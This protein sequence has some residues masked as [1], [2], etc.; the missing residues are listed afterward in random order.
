VLSSGIFSGA[1]WTYYLYSNN[2][3]VQA[4]AQGQTVTENFTVNGVVGSTNFTFSI[5]GTNDAAVIAGTS[6][7][8]VVEAGGVNNGTAG[9]PTIS[10]TLTSTDVDNA[11][12]SF[13]AVSS[14]T[15]SAGGYG[16]YTMTAAG[17]WTYTLN[18]SN[19]TV[20]AL[21]AGA[22]LTDTFTVTSVDGT[23]KVVTVTINGTNDAAIIA[24]T[25][26]G[27]V[28]EAGGMGNGTA[29]TPT[30]SGTLSSTDVDNAANSFTAVGTATTSTGG[31]GTYTV[32]AAGA[33][34]YTLNNSHITVQ[35]LNVGSTLTDTFT[36]TSIDGTQKVVTVTI[37]GTNDA[38]AI[39]GTSTGTVVEAG[40][41]SNGTAG[42]ARTP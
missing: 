22:T 27:T 18:N 14:A 12:N 5:I 28:V 31:Y 9:T 19:A 33:W 34:T 40:G 41:V 2:S 16:T 24:G 11:A 30:V 1:K 6:T 21:N 42:T 3:N 26:T 8:T 35:A 29:G 37:T 39:T 36:V 23:Q 38:A 25:S 17:V 20:Q 15:A 4:L 32:T 10:G 13:T 7:G